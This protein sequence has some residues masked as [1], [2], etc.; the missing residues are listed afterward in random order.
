A[1]KSLGNA[2][3]ASEPGAKQIQQRSGRP[4]KTDETADWIIYISSKGRF[5]LRHP[6]SWAVGP[7]QP[8]YCTKTEFS[9]TAVADADLVEDCGTEYYGQI[10]LLSEEGNYLNPQKSLRTASESYRNITR[11]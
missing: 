7:K 9:F 3:K 8:Q 10:Y 4:V 11:Q 1:G 5:S 6:K 2:D